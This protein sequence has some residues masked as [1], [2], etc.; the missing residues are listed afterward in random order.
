MHIMLDLE[1]FGN[2]PYSVIAS[3]GA[4]S[5]DST[6]ILQKFYR[7][8][9]VESCVQIGLTIDVSTMLWWLKQSAAARE[10]VVSGTYSINQALL[11]FTSFIGKEKATVWGNGA[12]FDNVLL[13]CAYEKAQL[14]VPW[15]YRNS[16]C[17]RTFSRAHPILSNIDNKN[18]HNALD[19]AETQ[20]L[21]LIETCEHCNIDLDGMLT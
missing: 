10:E 4:V 11:D 14:S 18:K 19:D 2:K 12:A 21:K 17:Y 7:K 3:I 5:F 8:I 16:F 20:A 13:T 9:D 6:G 15:S 1:T